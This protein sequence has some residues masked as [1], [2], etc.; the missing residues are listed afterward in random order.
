MLGDYVPQ[1]FRRVA[2]DTLCAA[3]HDTLLNGSLGN[4]FLY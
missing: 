3:L 4:P 1:L 2:A